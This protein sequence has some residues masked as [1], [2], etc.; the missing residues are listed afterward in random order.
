MTLSRSWR[1]HEQSKPPLSKKAGASLMAF[2]PRGVLG[3]AYP[4]TPL[5]LFSK[6]LLDFQILTFMIEK[7]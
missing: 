7:P 3:Y 1:Q 2:C 4:R 6:T 5:G